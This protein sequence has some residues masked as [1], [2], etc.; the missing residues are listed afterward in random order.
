MKENDCLY[1]F[2]FEHFGVRGEFVRLAASWQAVR[3]RHRCSA[4]AE[5]QLG[6]ALAAVALLSGTIKF[7]GSLTLQLQG[8]GPMRTLLAQATDQRT[9]RGMLSVDGDLDADAP[10]HE[11]LGQGRMTLTAKSPSGEMYQ[12]IVSVEHASLA[13]A[14][15]LYFEQS[16]QLPTRLWLAADRV[17]ASG[18]FLQRLPG[19]ADSDA[20][21]RVSMLAGTIS[22]EELQTLDVQTLLH[23]LFHEEDVR[24]FDPEPV[25]FRCSC[26]RE[27]VAGVLLSMGQAEVDAIIDEQGTVEAD[28]EFCNAHYTFDRVDAAALFSGGAMPDIPQST[29]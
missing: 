9:V 26:S 13:D 14:L 12:G 28:C 11:L 18:L 21:D 24:L 7:K 8:D 5:N 27:R 2:V 23:R 16:E 19:E 25:A 1:R 17:S 20:W 15:Q 6:A 3:D 29:Q 22:D 4:A 10:L